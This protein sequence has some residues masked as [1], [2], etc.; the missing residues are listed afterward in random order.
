MLSKE[1]G[2]L[3]GVPGRLSN[4]FVTFLFSI[5]RL[6]DVDLNDVDLNHVVLGTRE[7]HGPAVAH[8]R[9]RFFYSSDVWRCS[10][11]I[12]RGQDSGSMGTDRSGWQLKRAGYRTTMRAPLWSS[13]G[14]RSR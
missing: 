7:G 13:M 10:A 9:H 2:Y 4:G 6:E 14:S 5:G 12:R 11:A 8:F 3:S 1:L